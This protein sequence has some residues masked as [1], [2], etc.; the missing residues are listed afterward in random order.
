M[1][2]ILVG[3]EYVGRRSWLMQLMIGWPV[4]WA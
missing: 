3:C 2:L 4:Q 1:R